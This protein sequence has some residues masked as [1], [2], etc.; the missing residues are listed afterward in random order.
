MWTLCLFCQHRRKDGPGWLPYGAYFGEGTN[1]VGGI[2]SLVLNIWF[3]DA[4]L[5][6]P[7]PSLDLLIMV[8][9]L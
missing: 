8:L 1:R 9:F 6:W 5:W 3:L 7:V 4:L 2:L